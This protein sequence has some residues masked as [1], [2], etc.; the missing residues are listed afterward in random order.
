[1][2]TL[3]LFYLMNKLLGCNYLKIILA[4]SEIGIIIWLFMIKCL[5]NHWKFKWILDDV[6][7]SWAEVF[8]IE[9]FSETGADGNIATWWVK[10]EES[11]F[12]VFLCI[13]DESRKTN[14]VILI[15]CYFEKAYVFQ[16][17]ESESFYIILIIL[18]NSWAY[19]LFLKMLCCEFVLMKL[20]KE[21]SMMMCLSWNK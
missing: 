16:N 13:S 21:Q 18:M 14:I 6:K 7:W 8:V 4:F 9:N 20:N 10:F 2:I 19:F 15:D 11:Y 1:M 5:F 12:W 3:V 17:N